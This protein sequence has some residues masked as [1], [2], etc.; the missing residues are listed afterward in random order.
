MEVAEIERAVA[1]LTWCHS[2]YLGHGI[3]TP[4]LSN[5]QPL[6][7][8]ELPPLEGRTVLDVGAWDGLYSFRAERAGAK[9]VVALDHY[10]W[11]VSM[12]ARQAYWEEC[13]RAGVLPDHDRD[14]TDFWDASLPGRKGFDLAHKVLE[15]QV[16]PVV[17]DLLT[18]DLEVLGTFDVVLYLGVLYHM[19]EP[20]TA[21]RRVRAVTSEVA[22]IET[23][24]VRVLGQREASLMAFY[25]GN[26]LGG[27]D[28]GNWYAPTERALAGLCR[29]AGFSRVEVVRGPPRVPR[30]RD[31][32][33]RDPRR[34]MLEYR[35]AV[36]AYV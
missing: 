26:E 14:L 19:P 1:E 35:A 10:A 31:H 24:A 12:P 11:G 6:S 20:L 27:A 13:A 17:G 30:W 28:F 7:D 16:E 18:M 15:S 9:R 34:A 8:D 23:V 22:V 4:G 3:V 33:R 25:A 2:I 21:L 29:A 36:R 5:V 32:L